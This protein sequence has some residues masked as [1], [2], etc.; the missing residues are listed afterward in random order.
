[1]IFV[2]RFEGLYRHGRLAF[3]SIK[4]KLAEM[5]N[6]FFRDLASSLLSRRTVRI[7]PW[8]YSLPSR[9]VWEALGFFSA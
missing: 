2:A 8:G 1:M 7:A 3:A 5:S 9:Q 4:G 6:C